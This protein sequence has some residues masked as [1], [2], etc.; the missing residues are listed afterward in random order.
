MVV[1]SDFPG[2]IGAR[3]NSTE[4]QQSSLTLRSGLEFKY[5][6]QGFASSTWCF[7]SNEYLQGKTVQHCSH[8]LRFKDNDTGQQVGIH[9]C[10]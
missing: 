3:R 7:R 10:C 5:L 4:T 8:S 6:H 9:G 2:G 1:L